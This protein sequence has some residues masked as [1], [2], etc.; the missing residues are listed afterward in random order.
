MIVEFIIKLPK[1]STSPAC[2]LILPDLSGVLSM[3]DLVSG[4]CELHE[5]CVHCGRRVHPEVSGLLTIQELLTCHM[6]NV[7]SSIQ[8]NKSDPLFKALRKASFCPAFPSLRSKALT[9]S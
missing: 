2:Y 8:D 9:I 1:L 5:L 3:Y 4:E 6:F 7:N